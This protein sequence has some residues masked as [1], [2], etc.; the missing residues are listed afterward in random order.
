MLA[1]HV[2]DPPCARRCESDVY[3]VNYAPADSSYTPAA[4]TPAPCGPEIADMVDV[5]DKGIQPFLAG[6]VQTCAE[7]IP[8][9]PLC[10]GLQG[11]GTTMIHGGNT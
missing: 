5:E 1:A 8:M 10:P 6:T 2:T 9:C 4:T 11:F 7:G 3:E